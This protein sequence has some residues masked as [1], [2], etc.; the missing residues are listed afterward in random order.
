[1]MNCKIAQQQMAL[2]VGDDLAPEPVR[3]LQNH[4]ADCTDCEVLWKRHQRT[5]AVLQRSRDDDKL[6]RRGSVWPAVSRQIEKRSAMSRLGDFNGWFA[7]LAVAAACILV[8]VFSQDG[9]PQPVTGN[10]SSGRAVQSNFTGLETPL[11]LRPKQPPRPLNPDDVK[12]I[13]ERLQPDDF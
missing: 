2:A 4:L 12:T 7:G 6:T 10:P 1:M 8:F 13:R 5:F 11:E 9:S 3:Q